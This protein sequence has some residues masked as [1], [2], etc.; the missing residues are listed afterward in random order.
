MLNK[1]KFSEI[2]LLKPDFILQKKYADLFLKT[3]SVKQKM[4]IQS[5]ELEIGFQALMQKAFKGEL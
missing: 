2:E 5:E 4:L 1:S 3:E